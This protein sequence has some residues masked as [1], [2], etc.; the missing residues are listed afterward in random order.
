MK[1]EDVGRPLSLSS[2]KLKGILQMRSNG[3]ERAGAR[4]E[5]ERTVKSFKRYR[6]S[7]IS[8]L[9]SASPLMKISFVNMFNLSKL[10]HTLRL[11]PHLLG[12]PINEAVKGELEGLFLDK[13]K[14]Y[15][16]NLKN[17]M[18]MVYAGSL[19]SDGGLGPISWWV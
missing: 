6:A 10:E 15:L 8:F 18:L 7:C 1:T 5:I 16:P 2:P 9:L 13:V 12:L 14:L 19:V 3:I 17:L 11:Q 4:E